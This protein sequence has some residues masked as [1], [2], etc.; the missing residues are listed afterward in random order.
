MEPS[1]PIVLLG[2]TKIQ[3]QELCDLYLKRPPELILIE[4]GQW[5]TLGAGIKDLTLKSL[6]LFDGLAYVDNADYD[7]L[8]FLK[9]KL[10]AFNAFNRN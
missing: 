7:T 8:P 5:F 9:E 6:N 3:Q 2:R 1:I 10:A 4:F